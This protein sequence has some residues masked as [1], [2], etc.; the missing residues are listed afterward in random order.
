MGLAVVK[1]LGGRS[2]PLLVLIFALVLALCPTLALVLAACAGSG[3]LLFGGRGRSLLVSHYTQ[4][5]T[6]DQLSLYTYYQS[7]LNS[8]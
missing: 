6:R 8:L 5:K 1:L 7:K 2:R 3:L 4:R